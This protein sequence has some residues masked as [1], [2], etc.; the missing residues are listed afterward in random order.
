MNHMYIYIFIHIYIH[1]YIYIHV[2]IYRVPEDML[3]HKSAGSLVEGN[4]FHVFQHHKGN[5]TISLT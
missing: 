5:L 3:V 2:Y 1:I 4:Q